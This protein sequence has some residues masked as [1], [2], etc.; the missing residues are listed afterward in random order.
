MLFMCLGTPAYKLFAD[1]EAAQEAIR[2]D[3][4]N[5]AQVAL[6]F[7]TDTPVTANANYSIRTA[8]NFTPTTAWSGAVHC[9][10]YLA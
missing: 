7:H 8:F 2:D 1:D 10:L 6:T 5:Y 3:E 4:L 9:I